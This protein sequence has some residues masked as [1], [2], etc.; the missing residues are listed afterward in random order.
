VNVLEVYAKIGSWLT[1]A[2]DMPEA[3]LEEADEI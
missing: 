1:E 2:E 3:T